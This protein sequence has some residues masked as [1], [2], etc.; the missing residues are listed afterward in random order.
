MQTPDDDCWPSALKWKA[1][2][3]TVQGRLI[4]NEPIAKPC[5]AGDMERCQEISADYLDSF[6]LEESPV[7][8]QY[9]AIDTCA[10]LNS[11]KPLAGKP[12]CDLGNS[13]IYSI[14]AT[15]PAHV[16]AGIKFAK[17]NNVRLVIKN[18]GHDV[19]WR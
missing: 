6:T 18:T 8:Y 3:S 17:E 9:S 19:R 2:N 1:L 10:P 11:S 5:Y 4:A 13:P 16:A 12:M 7:G 15:G 14:N